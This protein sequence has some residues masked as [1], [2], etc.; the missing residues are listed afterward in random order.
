M[1][2]YLSFDQYFTAAFSD[3]ELIACAHSFLS[4]FEFPQQQMAPST[5][6]A[7]VK[8][9]ELYEGN[10]EEWRPFMDE[11]LRREGL[12]LVHT[13]WQSARAADLIAEHVQTSFLHR[14]PFTERCDSAKLLQRL[15]ANAGPFR[16]LKLPAELRNRVY[17][18]LL[19][20]DGDSVLTP[21]RRKRAAITQASRQLQEETLEIYYAV[22]RFSVRFNTH[23]RDI[24][25]CVATV[26]GWAKLIGPKRLRAVR[27]VTV[28]LDIPNPAPFSGDWRLEPEVLKRSFTVSLSKVDGLVVACPPGLDRISESLLVRYMKRAEDI[29]KA[30]GL[31]GGDAIVLPLIMDGEVWRWKNL[32]MDLKG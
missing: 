13:P 4:T 10:Y 8:G 26:L 15:E 20:G 25:D 28:I 32:T 24:G 22:S 18:L 31:E 27:S 3:H 21:I 16:F 23:T 9:G 6:N 29:R 14:V 30:L 17:D 7:G 11:T 1:A 2:H 19:T 5:S 12:L